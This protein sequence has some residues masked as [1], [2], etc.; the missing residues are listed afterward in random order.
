MSDHEIGVIGGVGPAATAEFLARV[1]AWTDA[2][3]DQEHANLL[4]IQHSAIP[5]RTAFLVGHSSDD[6]GPV[7]VSDAR[8]LE[9][10]GV[11]SI[12]VPC[13]TAS[14]FLDAM[15]AAVKIDVVD[16]I[17]AAAQDAVERG[18]SSVGI[19]ATAGTMASG[20]YSDALAAR[21]VSA[22]APRESAQQAVTALIYEDVKAGRT[23]RR[24]LF[25]TAVADVLDQGA[26]G[27]IL[28]CTELSVAAARWAPDARVLDALD[29]LAV[30]TVS[31]AGRRVRTG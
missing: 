23:P 3:T 30:R 13:N 11:A 10:W 2:A 20:A 7:L 4:V 29:S 22:I 25:E 16:I 17:D 19:L 28:G 6:P 8:R 15:R 18:W 5:D 27:V 31:L 24:E 9:S 26:D 21:G 1:V 14:A 12:V